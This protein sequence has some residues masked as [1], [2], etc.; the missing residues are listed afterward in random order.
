VA[1]VARGFCDPCSGDG[2]EGGTDSHDDLIDPE[3]LLNF[4]LTATRHRVRTRNRQ[5]RRLVLSVDL[6]GSRRIQNGPVGSSG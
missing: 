1:S 5:I 3:H 2:P 6:V 4:A